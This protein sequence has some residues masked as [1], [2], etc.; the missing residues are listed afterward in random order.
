MTKHRHTWIAAAA[1]CGFALASQA[2]TGAPAA[3]S[4]AF[5]A[6]A[7]TPT[8][9]ELSTHLG[10]KVF[11]GQT[12]AGQGWRLEFKTSGYVYANISNGAYDH[13]NWRSEDGKLCVAYQRVFP[14]GCAEVRI[15]PQTL[16]MLRSTGE[17]VSLQTTD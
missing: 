2:Q 6:T 4:P 13:G 15:A 16:Y 17:I 5:P 10:G 11:K 1:C 8:A 9:A 3:P 7:Q 12:S 14:S